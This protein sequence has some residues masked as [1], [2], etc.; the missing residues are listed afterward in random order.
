MKIHEIIRERRTALGMTQ[1]QVA[2][3]LGV[4]APAV[5]K[6]EKAVTCPD[7]TLL[8]A[9]ARLLGTD[10]NTLLSFQ[11]ELTEQEIGRFL[12]ELAKDAQEYG[13]EHAFELGMEKIREYPSCGPLILNVALTLQGLFALQP[14]ERQVS[15]H[16]NEIEELYKRAAKSKDDRVCRQAKAMLVSIYL[17]R[18]EYEE[19]EKRIDE[20]PD[21]T[22]VL[23][24]KKRMRANL[25]MKQQRWEEAAQL[26]EYKLLSDL[27]AVQSNLWLLLELAGKE[28]RKEDARRLAG[29]A[30]QMT[31]L[32]DLWE[33]NSYVSTFQLAVL[34]QDVKNCLSALQGMF[35]SILTPWS[36]AHSPLYRHLPKKKSGEGFGK[37]ILLGIIRAL[38]NPN[39]HEI[40]FLL[41]Y[42]EFQKLLEQWKSYV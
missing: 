3:Y 42:P 6:W 15:S 19:A 30:S 20:M 27:N 41:P 2:S 7:I 26:L 9:L 18:Q 29:A 28:G 4:S 1:E 37:E 35:S 5:N 21:E 25:L 16:T 38:E 17:N 34:E 14:T 32:F 31:S 39:N 11:E 23:T 36:T 33:Y 8:P 24:D 13:A 12:N 22:S 40:D 10:L